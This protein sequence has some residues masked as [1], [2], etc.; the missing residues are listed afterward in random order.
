M[1]PLI[2]SSPRT[3]DIEL[4]KASLGAEIKMI[5]LENYSSNGK[6]LKKF[7]F[8]VPLFNIGKFIPEIEE[9]KLG[10]NGIESI[11]D[12]IKKLTKLKHLS[13]NDNNFTSIPDALESMPK[14]LTVNLKGNPLSLESLLKISVNE[15]IMFALDQEHMKTLNQIKTSA[16]DKEI[17]EAFVKEFPDI[18]IEEF[19][20]L[21]PSVK[22]EVDKQEIYKFKAPEGDSKLAYAIRVVKSKVDKSKKQETSVFDELNKAAAYTIEN[23]A[24]MMG[25]REN[26]KPKKEEENSSEIS[27]VTTSLLDNNSTVSTTTANTGGDTI[28]SSY[29]PP[30]LKD[31]IKSRP[32]N[33][34]KKTNPKSKGI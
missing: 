12:D 13:L 18:S 4:I 2:P 23:L 11:H 22:A 26:T 27:S 20:N 3:L 5:N 8:E 28:N 32:K 15:K 29:T 1:K 16:E 30:V 25:S 19:N 34:H 24:E 10:Y 17:A 9:L 31:Q 7:N 14:L 33:A 21:L 6:I